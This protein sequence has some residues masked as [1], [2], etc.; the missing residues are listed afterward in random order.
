MTKSKVFLDLFL[1]QL[2]EYEIFYVLNF[3]YCPK[4]IF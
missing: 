1:E 4:N 3:L 2:L